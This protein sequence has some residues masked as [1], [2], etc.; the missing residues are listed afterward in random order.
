MKYI[1]IFLVPIFSWNVFGQ[2]IKSGD[3]YADLL[4]INAEMYTVDAARSWAEAMAIKDGKII[5][6]G[7]LQ[8]AKKY[9]S[10][11]QNNKLR[12]QVYDACIL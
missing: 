8:Q 6:V 1:F 12:R 11:H 9:Q 3:R 5:Y 7:S 2:T 10:K 4:F